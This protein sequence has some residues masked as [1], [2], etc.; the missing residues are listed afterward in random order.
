MRVLA[1]GMLVLLVAAAPVRA[2]AEDMEARLK[3]LETQLQ[4]ALKALAEQQ[5]LTQQA[6][7]QIEELKR[8]VKQTRTVRAAPAAA[9]PTL[10]EPALRQQIEEQ[11]RSEVAQRNAELERKVEAMKPAWD[12]YAQKFFKKVKLG[13]LVYGDWA[14]YWKTGFGPQFLTQINQPG[15]GNDNF[16][17]FDLSRA[18]LNFFFTPTDDLTLRVTPNVFRAVGT[19]SSDKFGKQGG[20]GTNLDGNL[21]YRLK[22]GYL[23]FNTPFARLERWVPAVAPLHD[24]KI[25]LGQQ[26]NPLVAWEE[27]LYGYRFTSLTPWNYTSL[28]SS[29]TGIAVHGPVKFDGRQ[30]IDYDLGVYNNANFHQFEQSETKQGMARVSVYPFGARSRFDGLGIT[31]FYD[32]GYPNKTRDAGRTSNVTRLTGLVHYT[33]EGWGIAGEYDQGR[34]AFSSSNLFSGSG[35]ADQFALGATPFAGFDGLVKALQDKHDTVQQGFALFGHYDI[36]RTPLSLFALW[37]R[38]QPNTNVSTNPIDF[39]RIVGGIG[40][41][42]NQYLRFALDVQDLDYYHSQFTFP[43]GKAKAL[44]LK[45]AVPAAVPSG[46]KAVFL[47]FEFSY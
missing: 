16:N 34:N 15:P 14:Y 29:Q 28:S 6:Q 13:T 32:Y 26:A 9:P 18:Y 12:D 4:Q 10:A 1:T 46:V 8:E 5:K 37:Q 30:Y 3:A 11:V 38:F 47:N 45:G 27:D 20:V 44:G 23:D 19:S 22:Y 35:P 21:E 41:K 17:S 24:D 7:R 25:T 2:R 31:G 43:A 39:D 42:Y 33:G 36:P 40:Y